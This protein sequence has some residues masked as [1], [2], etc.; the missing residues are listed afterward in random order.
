MITFEVQ[1]SSC[2]DD[3][4]LNTVKCIL[5][6]ND[7]EQYSHVIMSLICSLFLVLAFFDQ[8]F[9]HIV[10]NACSVLLVEIT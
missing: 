7:K 10:L 8:L 6:A 3:K 1:V 4:T 2:Q 9:W 5:P